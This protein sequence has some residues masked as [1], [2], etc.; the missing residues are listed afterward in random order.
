MTHGWLLPMLG[1]EAC[2]KGHIMNSG[3]LQLVLG[4][5]QLSKRALQ[6]MLLPASC[7]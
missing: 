5:R 2:G 3:W 7:L 4:L 6:G 1:L